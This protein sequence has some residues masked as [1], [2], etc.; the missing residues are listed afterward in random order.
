MTAETTTAI[1]MANVLMIVFFV[2]K[3]IKTKPTMIPNK[4]SKTPGLEKE[5]K[6]TNVDSLGM[7]IFAFFKPTKAMKAP[8][9]AQIIS[10]NWRGILSMIILRIGVMVKA[11]NMIPVINKRTIHSCQEKP[12]PWET[13]VVINEFKPIPVDKAIGILAMKPIKMVIRAEIIAVAIKTP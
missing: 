6:V 1:G 2:F 7:T 3:N 10:L 8:K 5:P 4:E 13:V 11:K 12:K 9:E